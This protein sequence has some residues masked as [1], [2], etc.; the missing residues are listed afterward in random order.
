MI[1]VVVLA[2]ALLPLVLAGQSAP[3]AGGDVLSQTRPEIS[4]APDK[5]QDGI[6][7]WSLV[8]MGV[9]V[10]AVVVGVRWA[11]PRVLKPRRLG[12]QSAGELLRV[13]ETQHVG[14]A[15]IHIIEACGRK[16]LIG[17]TPSSVELLTELDEGERRPFADHLEGMD[18]RERVSAAAARLESLISE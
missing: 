8:Q 15:G 10:G 2:L 11:L 9:A 1:R 12:V 4:T 16:F 13:V 3:K 18:I 6:G 5:A 14:P 17:V 7:W